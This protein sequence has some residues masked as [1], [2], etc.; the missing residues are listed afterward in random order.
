MSTFLVHSALNNLGR[1]ALCAACAGALALGAAPA[2][3]FAEG[4]TGSTTVTIQ[5]AGTGE[6]GIGGSQNIAFD[7]PTEIP[8][9]A[10]ADGTLIGPSEGACQIKNKSVFAIHVTDVTVAKSGNWN[11]VADTADASQENAVS[12]EIGPAGA[13]VNAAS[14]L[15][16]TSVSD[17]AAWNIGYAGSETDALSLTASG[18][19]ANVTESLTEAS[20]LA[21]ITWTVAAGSAS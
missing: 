17:N 7:V 12:L 1:K 13:L 16:G 5:A 14:A 15:S 4:N 20:A 8:L 10:Q 2:V 9:Y 18:T 19:I 3:S 6:G 11:I 21:T